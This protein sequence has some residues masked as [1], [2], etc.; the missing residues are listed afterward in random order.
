MHFTSLAAMSYVQFLAMLHERH[1]DRLR[2]TSHFHKVVQ[3][4][5]LV[6]ISSF[7]YSSCAFSLQQRL[8]DY[9]HKALNLAVVKP[10]NG[11]MKLHC[12]LPAHNSVSCCSGR[13][14]S[15]V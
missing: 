14:S 3:K 5:F 13:A 6:F 11:A 8:I 9:Q 2:F 1:D 7:S 10:L 4:E 15:L 12:I